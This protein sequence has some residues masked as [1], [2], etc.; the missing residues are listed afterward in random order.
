M[1]EYSTCPLCGS[2]VPRGET[3]KYGYCKLCQLRNEIEKE[4]G[5]G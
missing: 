1:P 2:L 4:K 3:D 5:E